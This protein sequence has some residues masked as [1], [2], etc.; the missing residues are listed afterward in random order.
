MPPHASRHLRLYTK[1]EVR[2][3]EITEGDL[4]ICTYL[5]RSSGR[6]WIETALAQVPE[7][8][9][10]KTY[11]FGMAFCA[12]V[13]LDKLRNLLFTFFCEEFFLTELKLV[14]CCFLS[15]SRI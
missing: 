14:A 3:R 15:R 12:D 8:G 4:L 2:S 13:E 5:R 1:P 7:D 11:L 6:R 9:E 10:T